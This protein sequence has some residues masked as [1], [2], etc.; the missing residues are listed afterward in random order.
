VKA[1]QCYTSSVD[2][3][4]SAPAYANRAL[5]C[6][7]L[8]EWQNAEADCSKVCKSLT[9]EVSEA[10]RP[11][12]QRIGLFPQWS[13]TVTWCKRL[14]A[15]ELDPDYL[16]AWQRRALVRKQ[17][18]DVAGCLDDLQAAQLLVPGSAA[19]ASELRGVLQSR[20][21]EAGLGL[22]ADLVTVPVKIEQSGAVS[23][24]EPTLTATGSI[25]THA[26]QDAG[27]SRHVGAGPGAQLAGQ[28]H[29][30][31]GTEA[32]ETRQSKSET[33]RAPVGGSIDCG[34]AA[35][36]SSAGG[37]RPASAGRVS[38]LEGLALPSRPLKPP[39][40]CSDFEGS[41]R[42]IRG[43]LD[44]QARY[45]Q[46]L[47]PAALPRIFK[48]SLSPHVLEGFVDTATQRLLVA[49]DKDRVA[50]AVKLLQ[51]LTRVDR[52]AV[53]AMLVPGKRRKVLGQQWDIALA[54]EN[55]AEHQQVLNTLRSAYKL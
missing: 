4:P 45:L 16:K 5:C 53:N 33:A 15:V 46:L 21:Q 54:E 52:F 28:G 47:D 12:A 44:A 23:V 39:A 8:K 13:A 24:E 14:Q 34:A 6:T 48:S 1:K 36:E 25:Y 41:W 9:L 7:K 35:S 3:L 40:T 49:G 55:M 18:F 20:L 37:S 11:C 2:A 17:L 42:S 50:F 10:A 43:D 51:S 19:V 31:A 27:A 32:V 38:P 26:S 29:G 30:D 22:P